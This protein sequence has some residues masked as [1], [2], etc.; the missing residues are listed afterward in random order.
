LARSQ[1][2]EI[3]IEINAAFD[4]ALSSATSDAQAAAEG[5]YA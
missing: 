2:A 3:R 4:F 1:E 5:V